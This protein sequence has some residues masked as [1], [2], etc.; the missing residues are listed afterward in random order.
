[1]KRL[2]IGLITL[3]GMLIV[4]NA[5]ADMK[6]AT[7]KVKLSVKQIITLGVTE[8]GIV[9]PGPEDYAM[10]FSVNQSVVSNSVKPDDEYG[11]ADR[12]D[13]IKVSIFTNA[14]AGATVYFHGLANPE[15]NKTLRVEDVYLTVMKEKTYV[16]L[17][18]LEGAWVFDNANTCPDQQGKA[19]WIQC[20]NE[21]KTFFG[22]TM[23]TKATRDWWLK[24]GIGNLARY[25]E[26]EEGYDMDLTFILTPIVA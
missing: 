23:S 15:H 25:T 3:L 6:H 16:L 26:N 5:L 11:F 7:V 17:N 13:A 12:A 22:V 19:K 24:L 20:D 10:E 21:A 18:E 1:M 14:R 9:I 8:P 2:T 4:T